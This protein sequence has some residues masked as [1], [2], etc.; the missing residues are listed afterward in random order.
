MKLI[1]QN[2]GN[3]AFQTE[4]WA[5]KAPADPTQKGNETDN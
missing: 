4:V 1:L 3:Y 5:K 2:R